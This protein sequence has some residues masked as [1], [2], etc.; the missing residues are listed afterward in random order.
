MKTTN[1]LLII[2]LALLLGGA[3]CNTQPSADQSPDK[4]RPVPQNF[5][6]AKGIY[7]AHW[8]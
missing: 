3:S 6:A 8:L 4:V 2:A 7:I 5:P 1:R